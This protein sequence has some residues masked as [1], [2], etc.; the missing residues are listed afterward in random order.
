MKPCPDT[1]LYEEPEPPSRNRLVN[2]SEAVDVALGH[3]VDALR[4]YS[5]S[6]GTSRDAWDRIRV[7]VAGVDHRFRDT[8]LA[9]SETRRSAAV[10]LGELAGDRANCRW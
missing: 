1:D 3:L 9:N 2:V 6:G 5:A 8:I 7:R 4:S 10:P